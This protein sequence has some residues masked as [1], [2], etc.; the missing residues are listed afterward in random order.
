MA[1]VLTPTELAA[2]LDT[3][4]KTTRK[5]LRS[6]TPKE[7]QPGKGARWSIEGRQVRSLKSQ[8]ARWD[9]AQKAARAERA[10]KAAD[11]ATAAVAE[12]VEDVTLDEVDGPTDED[13]TSEE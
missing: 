2:E 8:F 5:F 10:Q 6:I 4:A 3:D 11:D 13:L 7:N 12:D 1:K 9:A